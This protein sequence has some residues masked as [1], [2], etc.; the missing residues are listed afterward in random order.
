[1]KHPNRGTCVPDCGF[2]GKCHCGCGE[3]TSIAS[4]NRSEDGRVKGEPMIWLKGHHKRELPSEW[5]KR[6]RNLEAQRRYRERNLEICR[7]RCRE[8]HRKRREQMQHD[9]VLRQ[10]EA[11]RRKRERSRRRERER[12]GRVSTEPLRHSMAVN[13]WG[14]RELAV[15]A[16]KRHGGT[17]SAYERALYRPTMTYFMADELVVTMGIPTDRIYPAAVSA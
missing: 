10:R 12:V 6:E 2:Y 17:V 1:M 16:S 13:G 8:Y 9:E 15:A 11:N 3:P 14:I 7:Q 4:Y 5:S